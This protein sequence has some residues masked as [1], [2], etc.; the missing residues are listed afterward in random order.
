M[1]AGG[2]TEE[3]RADHPAGGCVP[4]P[5]RTVAIIGQ[6]ALSV[7]AEGKASG[8][9][10]VLRDHCVLE[11]ARRDIQEDYATMCARN[12]ATRQRQGVAVCAQRAPQ[13]HI[14]EVT[15]CLPDRGARQG[16]YLPEFDLETVAKAGVGHLVCDE[17]VALAREIGRNELGRYV[18]GQLTYQPTRW[19]RPQ[20]DDGG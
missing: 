18:E 5:Q 1:R 13:G 7:W 17:R 20:L 3:R 15:I 10:A 19:R 12:S 9:T 6:Q 8:R 11:C 16:V 2:M 4:E 14:H